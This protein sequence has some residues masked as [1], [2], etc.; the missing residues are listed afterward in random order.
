MRE[1][2]RIGTQEIQKPQ[3]EIARKLVGVFSEVFGMAP[4]RVYADL[5]PEEVEQWD[6]IGHVALVAAIETT[7][8]ISLDSDEV[9]EITSFR[10]AVSTL[11]KK[12]R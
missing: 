8:S 9:M 2:G 7:F 1:K 5:G 6:S 3:G 10:T 12:M 4:E 11:E